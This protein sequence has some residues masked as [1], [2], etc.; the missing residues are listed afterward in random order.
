MYN[1]TGEKNEAKETNWL[2]DHDLDEIIET[3]KLDILPKYELIKKGDLITSRKIMIIG[4]PETKIIEKDGETLKLT[5]ITIKDNDI[6][7][8]LPFNSKALQRSLV[9]LAIKESKAK[10]K[11]DIDFSKVLGK[12]IGIKREEFTAKGFTQAP[13]KFFSLDK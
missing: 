3:S 9:S 2:D 4:L 8:S 11:K 7:Y 6:K 13:H 12:L 10:T 1:M 5:F